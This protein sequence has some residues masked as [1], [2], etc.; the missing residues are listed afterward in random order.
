MYL[1]WLADQGT[2]AAGS[3]QPTLSAINGAHRD[4]GLDP[5]AVDSHF[6]T[7][8]RRGMGR[9]Q[10]AVSP[11]DTR[12]PLP[13]SV[14]EQALEA[15]LVIARSL[16]GPSPPSSL[17]EGGKFPAWVASLRGLFSLVL[18]SLFSGRADSTV[19]LRAADFGVDSDFMWIRLEEKGKR[20]LVVRRVIRLPLRCHPVEGEPSA[21]PRVA[22]LARA[23]LR[24]R[25]EVWGAAATEWLLQLPGEIRPTTRMFESWF[26]SVLER[27]SVRAPHGFAYLAHSVRSGAASAQAAIGVPR[28]IYV[29]VGGWARGSSVVDRTYIDPTVLPSPAA[30]RLYGWLL[31]RQYEAGSGVVAR[32]QPLLDPL[33]EG[34]S[35]V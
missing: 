23:W 2:I 10:S 14:V 28:H 35:D 26:M 33:L 29:W 8:V 16:M 32:F 12:V 25:E 24:V 5:P 9:A 19:H 30:Y 22:E 7:A 17:R 11:R 1:G 18:G 31:S 13:A 34:T 20:H 21:L 4:A 3:L 15:G 6:I 27:L